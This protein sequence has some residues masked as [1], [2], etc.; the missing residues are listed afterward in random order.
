M[1]LDKMITLDIEC[2]ENYLLVMFK[3]VVGDQVIYFEKFNDSDLHIKNIFHL[4]AR[5][6]IVTFNGNK[7]DAT[8]LEA[9]LA[10][11]SNKAIHRVNK[12]LIEE[13]QQPWQA[14]KQFGFTAI[15]M[16][17]I[18]LIEVAPLSASLKIYGGRMHAEKLQ[19]LPI[20]PSATILE[21]DLVPMRKYCENDNDLTA[22]LL[23][24]L[25]QELDLRVSMSEEYGVDLRSKSDAQIAE[26]VIKKEL[27]DKYDIQAT[28]PTI[29][30]GARYR[31][32]PPENLVFETE[33][34]QDLFRQYTTRPFTVGENGHITF[35]FEMIESDRIKSGKNKGKMPKKK[36]KLKFMI[37]DTKYTVGV[38]GI[39]SNEKSTHHT[40]KHHILREYDVASFYPRIVL[41]NKLAPKHL[42]LPFLK[43]YESIV[44]RRLSS[45]GLQKLA[46]KA[47]DKLKEA[48]H[49]VIN[50]SLKVVINGAFGKLG[51]KWSCLYSPDLMMQV[52]VTGQLTLLMLVE[53]LELAG[54]S[55]VSANTDGI[56]VK[57]DPA[58]ETTAQ[59][60]IADW[61]F[62]T[63]YEMEATDYQSLSSRDVNAY[64]A[65]KGD[66]VK[67][68]GAYAD[69]LDSFE[70][71]RHNPEHGVCSDAV[72]QF[73]QYDVPIEESV[74]ACDDI[75]KF[76]SIRTV[77]GGAVHDGVLL[78]KAIRWYYGKH[79]LD[80]IRYKT[81]GNKVPK[82]DGAV[83]MMDLPEQ[84]PTDLDYNWYISKANEILSDIG[85]TH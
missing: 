13:K 78:G 82:S 9:A 12:C 79:E 31:F 43:V 76:A 51:S 59:S 23:K 69:Q 66:D 53:Q 1:K 37:G 30:A 44:D 50:E 52:T 80:C 61:E 57:M 77:N 56:V 15:E 60:I 5:Y 48:I 16:D 67:G 55:V 34:L 14:R 85:Y 71:L 40:N 36:Q 11:F 81:T 29:K 64:I 10:G 18:D 35:D 73:L 17:H 4:L 58:L 3:Q 62:S 83:P 63:G 25:D 33:I 24:T 46:K 54:V 27:D 68:K 84:L 19:D 49:R 42:G 21:S 45:K 65:I 47:G 6:T 32:N 72:K 2:Y 39:H 28:R 41:N 20:E 74:K 8:I 38:G 22:Q 26:Q 7:Y 70:L 75:R